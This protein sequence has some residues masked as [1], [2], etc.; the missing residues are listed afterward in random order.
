VIR[1]TEF[2]GKRN[3]T[4][5]GDARAGWAAG[6]VGAAGA[7]S[8]GGE[9]DAALFEELRALRRQIADREHLPAYVIFHDATLRDMVTLRPSTREELLQVSGVG[10]VK[11]DKY[12]EEFLAVLTG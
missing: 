10:R 1:G 5:G 8:G 3:R 11:L 12:G 4:T 7:G 6:L 9:Y 2:R